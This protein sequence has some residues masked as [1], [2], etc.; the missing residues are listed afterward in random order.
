MGRVTGTW[1]GTKD[2]AHQLT[3]Y[4]YDTL[5]KGQPTSSTRYVG[6]KAGRRIRRPSPST[7]ASA[8][9]SQTS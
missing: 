9:P 3:E 5:L 6:G 4:T 1:D 7:T 8:A 2:D